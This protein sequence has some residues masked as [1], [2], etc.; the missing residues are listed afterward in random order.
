MVRI[1]PCR[2]N[3]QT[4]KKENK[5][6]K[7]ILRVILKTGWDQCFFI[8]VPMQ[9]PGRA[10]KTLEITAF[11]HLSLDMGSHCVALSGLTLAV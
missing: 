4:L 5:S 7:I 2:Q 10:P 8:K 11:L 9:R 6:L 3:T 1:H